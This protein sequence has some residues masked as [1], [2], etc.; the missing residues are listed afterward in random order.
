M[1]YH[2]DMSIRHY[3]HQAGLSIRGACS[4]LGV[5]PNALLR[6]ERGEVIPS[7]RYVKSLASLYGVSADVILA[8]LLPADE[9]AETDA[10]D[11]SASLPDL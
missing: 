9:D 2:A 11:A 5:S 4:A 1:G 8:A 3:R 6:W 10:R 7:A